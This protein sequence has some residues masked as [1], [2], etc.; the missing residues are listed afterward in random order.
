MLLAP[1]TAVERVFVAL[2]KAALDTVRHAGL[3]ARRGA[4]RVLRR[5]V[6]A[7]SPAADR[8]ELPP[9]GAPR[10]EGSEDLVETLEVRA[11]G[12]EERTEGR[13][14]DIGTG[15]GRRRK[16]AEGVAGLGE[17]HG[18]SVV[19]ERATNPRAV[20]IARRPGGGHPPSWGEGLG[21]GRRA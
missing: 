5:L 15:S 9:N 13:A 21:E 11:V 19:A 6:L 20:R 18:E 14:E 4:F 1:A 3:A 10:P 16:N 2:E 8:L 17:A 12:G 7:R